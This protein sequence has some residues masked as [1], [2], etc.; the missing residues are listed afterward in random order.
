LDDFLAFPMASSEIIENTFNLTETKD[1]APD[2]IVVM[3]DQSPEKW[4]GSPLGDK[5]GED[6]GAE[7]KDIWQKINHEIAQSM[8]GTGTALKQMV[9]Q[10]EVGSERID[11]VGSS[12]EQLAVKLQTVMDR[13]TALEQFA[14]TIAPT[15]KDLMST[16]NTLVFNIQ[17]FSGEAESEADRA[18]KQI[19]EAKGKLAVSGEEDPVARPASRVS[20]ADEHGEAISNSPPTIATEK[21]SKGPE[22]NAE[23]AEKRKGAMTPNTAGEYDKITQ[24]HAAKMIQRAWKTYRHNKLFRAMMDMSKKRVKTGDA[25]ANRLKRLEEQINRLE[26]EKEDDDTLDVLMEKIWK[27]VEKKADKVETEA[28]NETVS[29]AVDQIASLQETLLKLSTL[30]EEIEKQQEE[31]IKTV[32]DQIATHVTTLGSSITETNQKCTELEK[33]IEEAK[34][35]EIDLTGF[36]KEEQLDKAMVQVDQK[37]ETVEQKQLKLSDIEQE[38]QPV[39]GEVRALESRLT[40]MRETNEALSKEARATREKLASEMEQMDLLR[41]AIDAIRRKALADKNKDGEGEKRTKAALDNLE[42]ILQQQTEKNRQ[43]NQEIE[44][45]FGSLSTRVRKQ[46]NSLITDLNGVKVELS[47]KAGEE[48]VKEA[49]E[50]IE[51]EIAPVTDAVNGLQENLENRTTKNDV[52]NIVNQIKIEA[53]EAGKSSAGLKCLMCNQEIQG[54][55]KKPT[56]KHGNLPYATQHQQAVIEARM[57]GGP[58]LNVGAHP[59]RRAGALRP[60]QDRNRAAVPRD[61][62]GPLRNNDGRDSWGKEDTSVARLYNEKINKST[63]RKTVRRRRAASKRLKPMGYSAST[64]HLGSIERSSVTMPPPRLTSS[65]TSTEHSY[66][67]PSPVRPESMYTMNT[68][69]VIQERRL[70]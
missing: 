19:D 9:T 29:A 35:P 8:I 55:S 39:K 17:G 1:D 13:V 70:L 59:L 42:K 68:E 57:F 38:V 40:G 41:A 53:E 58:M 46:N 52:V 21:E 20:F 54:L 56:H 18:S 32:E 69:Q 16:V 25:L 43:K 60:V 26:E 4:L 14:S 61:G 15:V 44:G 7:N 67:R 10:I 51:T 30:R 47:K 62:Y 65:R 66:A 24:K 27:E 45:M 28:I 33:K 3:L 23:E 50:K 48:V 12:N 34:P 49:F 22:A 2:D 6:P 31:R 63:M 11:K 37:L 64:G 36:L 5:K